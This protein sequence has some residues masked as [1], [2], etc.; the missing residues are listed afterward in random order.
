M[1]PTK[2]SATAIQKATDSSNL[3]LSF[4]SESVTKPGVYVSRAVATAAPTLHLESGTFSTTQKYLVVCI[5]LNA[6][7]PSF[8]V[9]GPILHWIQTDLVAEGPPDPE[10]F[11]E[12]KA[13]GDVGPVV[14]YAGP[15]PPPG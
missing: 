3:K 6:P 11:V 2:G 9:L 13:E 10:G 14:K 5:D 12:L 7:F 8:P 4:G 15:G 1:P